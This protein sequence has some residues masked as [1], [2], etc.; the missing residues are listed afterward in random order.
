VDRKK[1]KD[2]VHDAGHADLQKAWADTQAAEEFAPLP[3]GE[4]VATIIDGRLEASKRKGTPG[5]HLIFKVI[6]GEHAGRKIWH[7]CWLTPAALPMTKRDLAK[8]QIT[9][10]AQLDGP[11][12]QGIR[13]KVRLALH[14]ED[15]GEE[16][17]KIIRF[18]VLGIDPPVVDPF[19]PQDT[20]EGG[21]A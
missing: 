19:A 2:I 21:A 15:T 7:T 6:G 9:D 10:L 4:Y 3:A 5:V 16:R 17:N 18:D 14:K 8:L 13:C 12:P 20:P 1:L 11:F